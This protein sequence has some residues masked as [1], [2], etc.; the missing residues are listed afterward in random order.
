[1]P[2]GPGDATGLVDWE[3]PGKSKMKQGGQL[4]RELNSKEEDTNYM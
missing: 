3:A 1:M 2:E 4:D